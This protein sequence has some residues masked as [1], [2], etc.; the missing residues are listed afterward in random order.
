MQSYTI[1]GDILP[2]EPL[3]GVIGNFLAELKKCQNE[4]SGKAC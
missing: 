2:R 1:A 4:A 3:M